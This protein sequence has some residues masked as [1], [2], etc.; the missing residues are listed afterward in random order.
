[1][2]QD[3]REEKTWSVRYLMS[4]HRLLMYYNIKLFIMD[5]RF[6]TKYTR[7]SRAEEDDKSELCSP[8]THIKHSHA[9]LKFCYVAT[10]PVR[11]QAEMKWTRASEKIL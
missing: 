5:E 3:E 2:D 11:S 1:M 6:G 9:S 4:L 7:I 8:E 10:R